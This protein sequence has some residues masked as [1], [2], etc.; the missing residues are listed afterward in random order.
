MI[1]VENQNLLMKVIA[2]YYNINLPEQV[3]RFPAGRFDYFLV[4]RSFFKRDLI[5]NIF[6]HNRLTGEVRARR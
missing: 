5:D 6:S 2:V 1:L 3:K 4:A